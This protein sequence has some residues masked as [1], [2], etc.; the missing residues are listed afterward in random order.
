VERTLLVSWQLSA[1]ESVHSGTKRCYEFSD[2]SFSL[3]SFDTIS[4]PAYLRMGHCCIFWRTSLHVYFSRRS[5]GGDPTW[6]SSGISISLLIS[7]EPRLVLMRYPF[8][9][10]HSGSGVA[11]S[12]FQRA[13][14]KSMACLHCVCSVIPHSYG[15]SSPSRT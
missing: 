13:G 14:T 3:V 1:H 15:S 6:R 8:E 11:V 4:V 2:C 9:R 5:L 12:C 10:R 7:H